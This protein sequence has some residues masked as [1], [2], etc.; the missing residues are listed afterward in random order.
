MKTIFFERT[1]KT[2]NI[3]DIIKGMKRYSCQDYGHILGILN[4]CVFQKGAITE[5]VNI[6]NWGYSLGLQL[7]NL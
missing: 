2:R 1:V 5:F 3:K 7:I 4:P 6:I